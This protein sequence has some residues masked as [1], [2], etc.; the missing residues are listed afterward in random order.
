MSRRAPRTLRIAA[1]LV[2]LAWG[3]AAPTD[4]AA[5]ELR[6]P[7]AL[8]PELLARLERERVVMLQ[9]F[10]EREPHGG[11]IHALVLFERPRDEVIRLL[12]QST[13][14]IEFRPELRRVQL[15]E[16]SDSDQLV[17]YE[18]RMMLLRV[19][20][21]ARHAW[22]FASGRVWWSLD[23]AFENDLAVLEGHWEVHAMQPGRALARFGT[24]I[25]VGPALPAFLQDYATRRRLPKAMHDVRRWIDSGGTFRP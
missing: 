24:R 3:A 22:D 14:Q 15:I 21:R 10:G 25:D 20:Y 8:A 13:R 18:L 17:E 9:E 7:E 23:P 16:E 4:S 5:E 19:R 2:P 1:L 11:P 6:L 12:I